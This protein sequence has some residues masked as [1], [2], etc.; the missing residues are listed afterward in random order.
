MI[1]GR[2]DTGNGR[3]GTEGQGAAGRGR[4]GTCAGNWVGKGDLET[5]NGHTVSCRVGAANPLF[6]SFRESCVKYTFL[7]NVFL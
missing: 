1:L 2:V 5:S 6:L 3:R 7:C 4:N